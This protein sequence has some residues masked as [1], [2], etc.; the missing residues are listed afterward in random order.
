M[1]LRCQLKGIKC[2]R[3][4]HQGIFSPDDK[5]IKRLLPDV[6]WCA[7]CMAC[8]SPQRPDI[9]E[10]LQQI[11]V[12]VLIE[13]GPRFNPTHRSGASFSTFIRPRICGTLMDAK[14]RE[15]THSNRELCS[16]DG[17]RDP[18]KDPD[19][20][21]KQD[22]GRL[23]EVPDPHADFTNELV[24]NISLAATL[25]KLL[26]TLTAREREVFACL[27]KDQRNC[28]IAE[29]LNLSESRVSQ[30]V[31]QVT[32]KLTDAAQRLGLAD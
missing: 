27:R 31:T 2:P 26:K 13:K 11:G 14:S 17:A 12:I 4:E 24:R 5:T 23:L 7:N 22:L 25:P 21:V 29:A 16:F 19:A 8:A 32:L 10:D 3:Y 1:K 15:L 18:S 28:E 20:E 9:Q 30:L 6:K